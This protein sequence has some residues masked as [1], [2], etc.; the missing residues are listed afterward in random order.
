MTIKGYWRIIRP[1]NSVVAGLAAAL[2]Y[3]VATG[4][5]IPSVILLMVI[6]ILITGAGNTINDYFDLS[7]DRINRPERPLPSGTVTVTGALLF[8]GILFAAGI[9]ISLFTNIFCAFFAVF[10]SLLLIAYAKTLKTTPFLG[11]L[12]VAFLAGSI[13]LF[14][15]A[16][17]GIPGIVNNSVIALITIL[18][19]LARELLKDAEDVPGDI[20]AGAKTIPVLYGVRLTAIISIIF[21]VFAVVVSFYPYYRWGAWYLA[22]IIPVDF[23][24]LY[25]AWLA[26]GCRS[27]ECIKKSRAT[28]YLKYGMFSSL[29]V[30]TLAA[31]FLA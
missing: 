30:F 29:I 18:A 8:A 9:L 16:L 19:M 24:I 1:V 25:S 11:N 20:A 3:L 28:S 21:T 5:I 26:S 15:G 13:F 23:I 7:I 6:V 22:G 4:T 17:A 10:N 27:P 14:G 12:S 31:I 2:G